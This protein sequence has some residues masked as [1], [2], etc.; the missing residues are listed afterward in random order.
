MFNSHGTAYAAETGAGARALADPV[1]FRALVQ[2][3]RHPRAYWIPTETGAGLP[4]DACLTPLARFR[5][6]IHVISGL[7]NPAARIPGPATIIT[8][9]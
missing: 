3:Q 2:R 5:N 8:G 9:R 4:A 7:D 1:A 6:D